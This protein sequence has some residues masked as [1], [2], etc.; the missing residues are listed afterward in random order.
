MRQIRGVDDHPIALSVSTTT[1]TRPSIERQVGS[2][3]SYRGFV[4]ILPHR[5]RIFLGVGVAELHT[6]RSGPNR[7]TFV[8]Q[9]LPLAAVGYCCL[10]R[11]LVDGTSLATSTYAAPLS[12]VQNP[13]CATNKYATSPS[14]GTGLFPFSTTPPCFVVLVHHPTCSSL[15]AIYF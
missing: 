7:N 6:V 3:A 11:C 10:A 5:L 8:L 13:V 4:V 15:T 14:F 12:P 9:M 2:L 1:G